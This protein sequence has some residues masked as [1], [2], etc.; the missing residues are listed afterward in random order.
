MDA[1][2]HH[3]PSDGP[4]GDPRLDLIRS[5]L[6]ALL[7]LVDIECQ[8]QVARVTGFRLKDLAQWRSE[9]VSRPLDALGALSGACNCRCAFCFE[10]GHPFLQ[11]AS[12]LSLEEAITRLRYWDSASSRGL[13]PPARVFKEPFLNPH[14]IALWRMAR[15]RSQGETFWLTS[16]GSLLTEERVAELATLKPVMLKLSFNSADPALR[17]ELMGPGSRPDVAI[18][19]TERLQRHGIPYIGSIVAWP[20]LLPEDLVASVR[21]LDRYAPYSIRVRLPVYHRYLYPTPPFED[22]LWDETIALCRALA[23]TLA[24]P[25]H[26]E[27]SLYWIEP[28]A[29]VVDGIIV[30]S[31]AARAGLRVGDRITRIDGARVALRSQALGMLAAL[32]D[33]GAAAVDIAVWREAEQREIAVTLSPGE[34]RYPYDPAI[35]APGERYGVLLLEDLHLAHVQ[36][37]C[38]LMRQHDSHNALLFT[39][40]VVA[41][42]VEALCEGVPD[43]AAFFADRQLIIETLDETE[44]GGNYALMDGRLVADFVA[45]IERVRARSGSIPDMVLIPNALGNP[46][47]LDYQR[48]SIVEIERRFGMP[49]ELIEWPILYGRDV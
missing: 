31:P 9:P 44:V 10:R 12:L 25:L 15:K 2:P 16:N 45:Q 8:G 33:Q 42:L 37:V 46:W 4:P 49:V 34:A 7:R 13:P 30:G 43:F 5:E 11:D 41:P 47:G 38:D 20:G 3:R 26:V 21:H 29:P 1:A 27:P 17:A 19:A 14:A 32:H 39:S 23:P 48:V 22:G 18:A 40:P 24:S 28:L 35:H 36:Q 6:E